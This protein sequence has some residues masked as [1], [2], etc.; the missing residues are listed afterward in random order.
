MMDRV[1][2]AGRFLHLIDR[3]GWEFVS[4]P[5]S[6]GIVIIVAVTDGKLILVEQLRRSV[7][8]QVIGLPAGL[9][10]TAQHPGQQESEP[11]A[12]IRELEEE[13]G[14]TAASV[15]EVARGPIS[16]GATNEVMAI[17]V[18]D[19]VTKKGAQRLDAD[20]D[21]KVHLVGLAELP[22]WLKAREREGRMIDLKLFMGLSFVQPRA[23]R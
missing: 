15:R 21:I 17:F 8:C 10:D 12:A 20:E 3:D 19:G 9:V 14:Y 2:Y 23:T 18:A 7:N 22:E 6:S 4:R 11:E 16:P 13:T 1:L 5:N